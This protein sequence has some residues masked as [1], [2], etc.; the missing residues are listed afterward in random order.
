MITQIEEQ[1]VEE[2]K[3]EIEEKPKEE[4][5]KETEVEIKKEEVTQ[6]ITLESQI[7]DES[8]KLP[9]LSEKITENK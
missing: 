3:T 7:K 6:Q 1:K 9:T 5:N 4:E 2:T 8:D